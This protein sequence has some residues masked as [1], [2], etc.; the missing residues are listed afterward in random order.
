MSCVCSFIEQNKRLLCFAI[1][2]I[3]LCVH[4]QIARDFLSTTLFTVFELRPYLKLSVIP[5]FHPSYSHRSIS[6]IPCNFNYT[7]TRDH[8]VVKACLYHIQKQQLC[9]LSEIV[10]SNPHLLCLQW[11]KPNFTSDRSL[12]DFYNELE[13]T[14]KPAI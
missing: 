11:K 1:A 5:L 14:S 7:L 10:L 13:T 6:F 4:V 9:V 3:F 2:D 12:V 8:T